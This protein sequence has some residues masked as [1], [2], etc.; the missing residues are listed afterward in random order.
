LEEIRPIQ[1]TGKT[2]RLLDQTKIPQERVTFEAR[3]Y[4]E[5]V[6][7]IREMRVRGAPAIGVTAAYAVAMAAQDIPVIN[8]DKFMDCLRDAAKQIA[9]ARPT[10]VNLRWAVDRMLRV[11][12][13]QSKVEEVTARLVA[14][15]RQLQ[16]E[17]EE[18]N[19]RMGDHG[20]DL[21][22]EGGAVLTHCNTGALATSAFGTALGVIRAGWESGK[23]FDVFNTET[24]PFL[25]GAR[26]TSWEFQQL[27]IPST[28]IVDSAAGMMM[29][30]GKISC[31]ITGADRIAANGDTANKVG[32]YS[33]AVLAKENNLPFYVAAPTSTVDLG[34]V[35]GDEIQ[36]EERPQEEVTHFRGQWVAPEGISAL[37]PA[38]DVT[39][40]RF[41]SA[42]ITES[43]IAK[44]PYH[45][46]LKLAVRA[47]G[48]GS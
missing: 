17:D 26:L 42:I 16:E 22:P 38:F 9:A 5:A 43:G 30:R 28:L 4:P 6:D 45:E 44:P 10:A 32:T 35:T 24:R 40:N 12:E 23:R 47:G 31:V 3:S 33:L 18:I 19:R 25:Q 27:G 1:W 15:A 39:P 13:A 29:E 7:A 41:I 34:L 48:I 46:S 14:E 2:I 20:K 21:M 37:N 11:A 8:P 36:I